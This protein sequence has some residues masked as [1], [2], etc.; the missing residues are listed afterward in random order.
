MITINDI[1]VRT[2]V[3][4]SDAQ[5]A[6]LEHVCRGQRISRAE[7]VRRA[8]DSFLKESQPSEAD[9]GFG[10]WRDKPRD[11]RLFVERLRSEWER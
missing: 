8:V 10:I 6:A 7:A 9:T 1:N 2:I 5:I 3:S 4:F 11:A